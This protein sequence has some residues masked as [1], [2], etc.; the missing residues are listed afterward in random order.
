MGSN[1]GYMMGSP[2]AAQMP[3]HRNAKSCDFDAVAY[4]PPMSQTYPMTPPE[5]G[6]YNEYVL[7]FVTSFK[8]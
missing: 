2:D 1:D 3:S 4:T 7:D 5:G 8:S 6:F